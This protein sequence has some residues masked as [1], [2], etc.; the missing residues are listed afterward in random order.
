MHAVERHGAVLVAQRAELQERE[1]ARS[2][3]EEQNAEY[4]QS[5]AADRER[6]A[7]RRQQREA[8][9]REERERQEAVMKAE[10]EAR[11]QEQRQAQKE[12]A[13]NLRRANQKAL[14][15]PEPP[16][17][18]SSD[19]PTA[20]VRLRL[21]DGSTTQRRFLSSECVGCI[22]NFV[23]SLDTTSFLDYS[24]ISSFPRRVFTRQEAGLG[25][26]EAGIAPQAALFVQPE[27][28]DD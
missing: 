11:A 10:A 16:S 23:D 13:I 5:L 18:G 28:Y 7:Q 9:E 19:E 26:K 15:P 12:A 2:L 24:I 8:E 21:P 3:R 27:V 4:E 6:E 20:L 1:L 25:L 14:L 22:F 17:T